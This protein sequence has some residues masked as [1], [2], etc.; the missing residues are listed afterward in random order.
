MV[1]FLR[2]R[3][4]RSNILISVIFLRGFFQKENPFALSVWLDVIYYNHKMVIRTI[5]GEIDSRATRVSFVFQKGV[6]INA[7]IETVI[8][9]I[10]M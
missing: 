2:R 7:C 8:V 6:S 5:V 9:V 1:E 10:I 3:Y 4:T